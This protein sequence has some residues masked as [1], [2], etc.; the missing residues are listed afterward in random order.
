M[1]IIGAKGLAKQIVQTTEQVKVKNVAFFDNI[2]LEV[3][4]LYSYPILHSFEE[5]KQYFDNENRDFVVGIGGPSNRKKFYQKFVELGGSP[6]SLISNTAFIGNHRI[7]IGN[8]TVV[9]TNVLV[10]NDVVIGLGCLLNTYAAIHHDCRI[11][12]FC[13]ISPRATILGEAQIGNNC[14]VGAGAII[15][16]KVKVGNNVV[17]GA[18]AVVTKDIGDGCVVKGNPAR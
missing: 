14:L 10:E 3:N 5:V 1:I 17:V 7:N 11:G 13:E 18:G 16:P 9:L 15:L 2:N 12:N 6:K 4:A 8:G